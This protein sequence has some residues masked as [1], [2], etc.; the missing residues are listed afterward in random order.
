MWRELRNICLMGDI[1]SAE[2]TKNE[3]VAT[4]KIRLMALDENTFS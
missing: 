2:I 4:V 3:K 1:S